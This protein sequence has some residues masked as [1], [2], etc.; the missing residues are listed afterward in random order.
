LKARKFSSGENPNGRCEEN[1]MV[2]S[3]YNFFPELDFT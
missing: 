3:Q 1:D 2:N